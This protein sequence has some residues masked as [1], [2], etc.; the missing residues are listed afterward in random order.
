MDVVLL[1]GGEKRSVE[2]VM[3]LLNFR[4]AEL[5]YDREEEFNDH[6]G[7]FSFEGK[8]GIGNGAF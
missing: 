1:V 7:S 6:K 5:I 3:D 8:F 2:C 4:E